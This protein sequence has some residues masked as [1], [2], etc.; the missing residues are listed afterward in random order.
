MK[1]I[2]AIITV[3]A[4][5][6]SLASFAMAA[7]DNY[8]V[9]GTEALTGYSWDQTKNQMTASGSIYTITFQDVAAGK[10]EFKVVK[11]S[12]WGTC[13]PTSNYILDTTKVCDVTVNFDPADNSIAILLD[14]VPMGDFYIVAG[15]S[16]L[17]NGIN[18]GE[19][20]QTNRMT[21]SGGVYTITFEDVVPGAYG[22]KVVKNG[23][24]NQAWPPSNYNITVDAVS[25][26]TVTFDP[27]TNTAN[28]TITP[29]GEQIEIVNKFVVAG[30]EG[31]TG[32]SWNP[33]SETNEMAKDGEVYKIT[34]EDVAAGSY[35]FKIVKNGSWTSSWPGE[36]YA[37]NLNDTSDVTITFDPS[38]NSID[39]QVSAGGVVVPDTYV[40]AGVAGLCG[41]EWNATDEA[42]KMTENNGVY[43]I[44]YSNVAA[45]EY[46][47]KVVKNGGT[48]IGGADGNNVW[49]S[50]SE[51]CDVTV[52]YSEADGI[53]VT[54]DHVGGVV[55][56]SQTG[57]MDLVV[58]TAIALLSGMALCA[59][60][61]TKK[62][63]F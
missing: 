36:N 4:L 56:P 35:G 51:A 13:W 28:A 23:D 10:H 46:E 24:W 40:V 55:P 44:T 2:I 43:S 60:T 12:D 20:N 59:V 25:D 53:V 29:T 18:W 58:V 32:E 30:D 7:G 61:L 31:L 38:D 22:F 47:L 5:C 11:N 39:V 52:T 6:L 34:F 33:T 63:F 27:S 62:K 9:A 14:G 57:D 17:C 48:W 3:L 21:L 42:N 26:V 16:G 37:L 54:G 1:K 41:S 45:G 49:F 19:A 50:V 15:D 8:F